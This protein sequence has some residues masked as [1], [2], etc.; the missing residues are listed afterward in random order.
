M[1]KPSRHI[2]R[3]V[4]ELALLDRRVAALKGSGDE[5]GLIA[6]DRRRDLLAAALARE[7]SFTPAD[8]ERK[9]AILCQRLRGD[10]A[11]NDPAAVITYLLAESARAAAVGGVGHRA[12]R[13]PDL[14][15]PSATSPQVG[16]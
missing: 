14:A 7:P 16:A 2:R 3:L 4:D 15:R 9:L 5:A 6:L 8:T 11:P 12:P 1:P 10:L 13:R